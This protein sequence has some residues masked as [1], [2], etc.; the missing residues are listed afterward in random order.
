MPKKTCK[1]FIDEEPYSFDVKGNF[2]WGKEELLFKSENNIISKTDW[3]DK[4]FTVVNAF[5]NE[6]FE[7]L[8]QSITTNIIKAF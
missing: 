6:E 3:K 4:G 8:K 5:L 7:A 2:F 1:L